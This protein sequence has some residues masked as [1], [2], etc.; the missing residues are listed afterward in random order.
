MLAHVGLSLHLR[1]LLH[2]ST[3]V[4]W[5]RVKYN[6]IHNNFAAGDFIPTLAGPLEHTYRLVSAE[7]ACKCSL[8]G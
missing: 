4:Y 3:P 6:Q 2:E 7:L 5:L 8:H 1:M